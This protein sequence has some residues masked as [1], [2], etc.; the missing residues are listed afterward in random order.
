MGTLPSYPPWINAIEL[1]K[2]LNLPHF[3][4]FDLTGRSLKCFL[5]YGRIVLV[6][7]PQKMPNVSCT[8]IHDL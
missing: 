7:Y 3:I 4:Y 1:L 6:R 5:K 2:G 8:F